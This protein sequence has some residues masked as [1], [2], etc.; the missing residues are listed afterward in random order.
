MIGVVLGW[1]LFGFLILRFLVV[2]TNYITGNVLE[3]S[4]KENSVPM[5]SILIPVRNE[6]ENLPSLLN[7]LL[8]IDYPN[9][10]IFT[11]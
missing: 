4:L 2:L 3:D 9:F 10:E 8:K 5:V 11:V 1:A 7:N 6:A